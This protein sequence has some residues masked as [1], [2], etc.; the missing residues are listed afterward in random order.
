MGDL[1]HGLPSSDVVSLH[2]VKTTA[3]NDFAVISGSLLTL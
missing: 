1:S 2:S 3:D